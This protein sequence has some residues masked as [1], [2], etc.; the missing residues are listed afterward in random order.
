MENRKSRKSMWPSINYKEKTSTYLV[1]RVLFNLE[2]ID[3]MQRLHI[4]EN[5]LKK[6]TLIAAEMQLVS[7]AIPNLNPAR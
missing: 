1:P 7:C 5:F 2:L 4:R 6:T 3:T